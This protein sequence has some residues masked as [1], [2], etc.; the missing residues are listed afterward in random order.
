LKYGLV[1]QIDAPVIRAKKQ[2][3]EQMATASVMRYASLPS[4][5]ADAVVS[6]PYS[7]NEGK[8]P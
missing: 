6:E 8:T 3:A 2:F 7:P 5:N 1:Q 4:T